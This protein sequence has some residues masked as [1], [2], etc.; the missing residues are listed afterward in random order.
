MNNNYSLQNI[1]IFIHKL[2]VTRSRFLPTMK[3]C[4]TCGQFGHNKRTCTLSPKTPCVPLSEIRAMKA[5]AALLPPPNKS[6]KVSKPLEDISSCQNIWK[7]PKEFYAKEKSRE[8]ICSNCGGKGHNSRTCLVARPKK[9]TSGRQCSLC[10]ECG[11]NKRTCLLKLPE[12]KQKKCGICG[13]F[14]HNSR[15]CSMKCL[16]C[17][18]TGVNEGYP[19]VVEAPTVQKNTEKIT[20]A[21]GETISIDLGP[22]S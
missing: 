13:D 2:S 12:K 21:N 9:D 5:L 6:R 3:S 22:V 18:P 10:G 19:S 7:E 16:P 4:S 8:N 15:T 11:H 20:F 14:G 1:E 17:S